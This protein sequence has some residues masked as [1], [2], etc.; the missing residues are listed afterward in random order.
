VL[1][2]PVYGAQGWVCVLNPERS[3][4]DVIDLVALAHANAV[5]RDERRGSGA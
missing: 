5:A 1:P 3:F 4:T 2:H